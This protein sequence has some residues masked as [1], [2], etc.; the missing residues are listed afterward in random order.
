MSVLRDARWW[1]FLSASLGALLMG[2]TALAEDE[3]GADIVQQ[4]SGINPLRLGSKPL[5]KPRGRWVEWRGGVKWEGDYLDGQRDGVWIATAPI[6]EDSLFAGAEYEGFESPITVSV[7]LDRNVAHGEASALDAQQRPVFSCHLDQGMLEGKATWWHANGHTRRVVTYRAGLLDGPVTEWSIDGKVTR[8]DTFREGRGSSS[9]IEWYTPGRK[10]YEGYSHL[11]GEVTRDAFEWQELSW[12]QAAVDDFTSDERCGRWIAWYPNGQ[13]KVQGNYDDG[14]AEG[15]F[16][17]FHENGQKHAE[18]EY[19]AGKRSG[20]W[21][22]WHANGRKQLEGEFQYGKPAGTW[23][24][25]SAAGEPSTSDR[26]L[27]NLALDWD[28]DQTDTQTVKRIV[29]AARPTLAQTPAATVKSSPSVA[30]GNQTVSSQPRITNSKSSKP[31]PATGTANA[32]VFP[33][34]LPGPSTNTRAK[35]SE[36]APKYEPTQEFTL[37]G[38]FLPEASPRSPQPELFKKKPASAS[39]PQANTRRTRR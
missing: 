15:R 10:H 27:S 25:W 20:L 19:V 23:E 36:V 14:T 34:L 2:A 31:S 37:L 28:A 9:H 18:G 12:T 3:T 13:K 35:T 29:P 6:V 24:S 30:R 11:P 22:F 8:Q 26:S 5:E 7:M 16:T 38:I 17:W 21:R 39:A 33:G 4:P 32:G 1:I